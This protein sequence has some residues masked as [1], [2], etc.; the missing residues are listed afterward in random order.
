M[1]QT[2]QEPFQV[3]GYTLAVLAESLYLINLLLLPGLAFII[4]LWL[5][6]KYE[7]HSPPLASCHLRQTLAASIWA[8]LLL[9]L[10]NGI[11]IAMGGYKAPY[12]GVIV[13]LYFTTCHS[14]LVLLGIFGLSKAMAGKL[15]RYPLMGPIE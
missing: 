6:V 14:L 9:I 8:G 4:L 11:I 12:T 13:I 3:P 5:Y 2:I 7:N 1:I 15:F 10:I